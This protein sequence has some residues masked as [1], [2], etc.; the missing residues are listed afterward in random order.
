MCISLC[1]CFHLKIFHWLRFY[2]PIVGNFSF[3][4]IFRGDKYL[5]VLFLCVQPMNVIDFGKTIGARKNWVFTYQQPTT[6]DRKSWNIHQNHRFDLIQIIS[7]N[8]KHRK[9][10]KE[11]HVK[12]LKPIRHTIYEGHAV[13]R[14]W[15]RRR[16]N[17]IEKYV[18]RWF[19]W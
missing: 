15:R 14:R 16:R 4:A 18:Y 8:I 17:W 11:K 9:R 5:S 2:V 13:W 10:W 7:Y 12:T 1:F 19:T 6:L 3:R